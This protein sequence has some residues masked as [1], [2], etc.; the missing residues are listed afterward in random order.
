MVLE[1]NKSILGF[2]NFRVSFKPYNILNTH[3][4]GVSTSPAAC[5]PILVIISN[6]PD[7]FAP[8]APDYSRCVLVH[9]LWF[10]LLPALVRATRPDPLV[11][12]HTPDSAPS[13]CPSGLFAHGVWFCRTHPTLFFGSVAHIQRLWF[14]PAHPTRFHGSIAHTQ[15]LWFTLLLR[16]LRTRCLVP[17]RTLRA[18]FGSHT[19]AASS[20]VS[21]N[22]T[23]VLLTSSI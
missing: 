15:R 6:L 18:V 1:Q 19:I 23:S 12:L 13:C 20:R 22:D 10:P 11:P 21:S 8:V 7:Q 4:N 3:P 2:F 5:C 17:S 16:L 9:G 14:R